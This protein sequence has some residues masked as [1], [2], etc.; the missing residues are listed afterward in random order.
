MRNWFQA[1]WAF[2]LLVSVAQA[3]FNFFDHM[4]GGNQQQAQQNQG[5]QNVPSDSG[6]YQKMWQQCKRTLDFST[7]KLSKLLKVVIAQLLTNIYYLQPNAV[8]IFA[9]ELLPACIS[10]TTALARILTSKRKLS[11]EKEV[12]SVFL[13][14]DS[15]LV[16]QHARLNSLARVSCEMMY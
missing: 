14:E 2:F 3:Q 8:T 9:R 5:A 12:R 6:R 10:H 15:R 13:R 1:I 7:R 16:R 4:F 11:L